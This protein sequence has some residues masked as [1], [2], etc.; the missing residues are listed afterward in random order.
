MLAALRE[1]VRTCAV[2]AKRDDAIALLSHV[3]AHGVEPPPPTQVTR[4]HPFEAIY[5]RDRRV[6]RGGTSLPLADIGA[7]AALQLRDFPEMNEHALH[8]AL[9]DVLAEVFS[10]E[11][12]EAELAAE[13]ERFV[14]TAGSGP[15]RTS[16]PGGGR[17]TSTTRTSTT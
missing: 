9:V 17:T 15:T 7:Y 11:P 13:R 5:H 6:R 3:A 4:S 2:D 14:P 10:V 16:T 8:A 12:D 1:F